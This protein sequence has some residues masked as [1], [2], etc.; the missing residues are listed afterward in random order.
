LPLSSKSFSPNAMIESITKT[1]I[2]L[3]GFSFRI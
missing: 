1:P 3:L 2:S